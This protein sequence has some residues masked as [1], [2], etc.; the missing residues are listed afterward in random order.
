MCDKHEAKV[1]FYVPKMNC[2][3]VWLKL[4][5]GWNDMAN[6]FIL[7]YLWKFEEGSEQ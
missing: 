4:E 3:F 1:I 5:N 2:S 6:N 7:K